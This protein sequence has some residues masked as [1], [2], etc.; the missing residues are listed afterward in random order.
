MLSEVRQRKHNY[1]HFYMPC[2]SPGASTYI[3]TDWHDCCP[4]HPVS[5]FCSFHSWS[6][7][8]VHIATQ[9]SWW[10]LLKSAWY[11]ST[12]IE[13]HLVHHS[14]TGVRFQWFPCFCCH[15]CWRMMLQRRIGDVNGDSLI[16]SSYQLF[17]SPKSIWCPQSSFCPEFLFSSPF[18]NCQT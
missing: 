1:F 18:F 13:F 4:G 6:Q 10:W 7:T 11:P 2:L 3:F 12:L 8:F 14:S 17:P 9:F 16:K 5:C 15:C